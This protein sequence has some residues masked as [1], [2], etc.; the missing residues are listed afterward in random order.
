MTNRFL[1][2][3]CRKCSSTIIKWTRQSPNAFH[4]YRVSCSQCDS[5]VG[6]GKASQFQQLLAAGQHFVTAVAEVESPGATLKDWF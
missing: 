6:W 5:F 4:K 3:R 2:F 1:N